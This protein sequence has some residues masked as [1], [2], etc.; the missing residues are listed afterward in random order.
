[1]IGIYKITNLVNDKVYIGQSNCIEKRIAQHKS[2]YEQQRFSSKPL[3]QAF[4]KYGID[5]FKFEVVE[6]CQITELDEKEMYW[7]SQCQS[8]TYQNGYNVRSGGEG[9]AGENHP[10]HKMT[11]KDVIDIRTRYNNRERCKDVEKM[12]MDRIGRSGFSKI[13]KGETWVHIMPEVYTEGNKQFHK[14]NTG[15]QGSQNGRSKLTEED[16]ISIRMRK[17][18]GEAWD[19]VYKD[20]V[21]TGITEGSFR[22]TWRGYNWKHIIV[23]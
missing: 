20:Y 23:E 10:R 19:S 11:E 15:Q 9:N 16:V 17:K 8:L 1:M 3:Y 2:P 22:N 4:S 18:N 6:E 5:N 13:W 7:I 12:Y 21:Y 14:H